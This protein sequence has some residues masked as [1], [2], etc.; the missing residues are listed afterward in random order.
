[1]GDRVVRLY[2]HLID[3]GILNSANIQAKNH[4]LEKPISRKTIKRYESNIY[5][6]D[7]KIQ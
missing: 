4:I 7:E 6:V 2:R 3:T 5:Q 1:L